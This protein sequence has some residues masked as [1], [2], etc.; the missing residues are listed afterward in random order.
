MLT[1]AV[2][3]ASGRLIARH[4]CAPIFA[5]YDTWQRESERVSKE[6]HRA[7]GAAVAL[8]KR[9]A[10]DENKMFD[11][12]HAAGVGLTAE[13]Q[14]GKFSE[15]VKRAGLDEDVTRCKVRT[16][17]GVWISVALEGAY[18]LAAFLFVYVLSGSFWRPPSK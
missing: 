1:V 5:E 9:V 11:E 3:N 17:L 6:R 12:S 2:W 4:V 13:L 18:A 15:P 10:A 8:A 14:E 7:S 16:A